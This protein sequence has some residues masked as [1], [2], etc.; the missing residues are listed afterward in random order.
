M[1][2]SNIILYSK[3]TTFATLLKA[4]KTKLV[5]ALPGNPVSSTVTFY[6]FVLPA[7]RKMAGWS[8]PQLT[9][10]SAKVG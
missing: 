10:I 3:P 6:L 4:G 8:K 7:L 5:F 1:S 2:S 9:T